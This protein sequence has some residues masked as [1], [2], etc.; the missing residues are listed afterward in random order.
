MPLSPSSLTSS[1]QPEPHVRSGTRRCSSSE[2]ARDLQ[3]PATLAVC[4][5]IA[6]GL[7]EQNSKQCY[8]KGEQGDQR[9]RGRRHCTWCQKQATAGDPAATTAH[10]TPEPFQIATL[11]DTSTISHT[12]CEDAKFFQSSTL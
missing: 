6:S 11:Y 5:L 7:R 1:D 2:R 8:E 3:L 9:V 10:S 4:H 12:G